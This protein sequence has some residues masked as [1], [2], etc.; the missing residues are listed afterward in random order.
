M[1]PWGLFG[2]TPRD[3]VGA[4]IE[5]CNRF[6][7]KSGPG[8]AVILVDIPTSPERVT[9][10]TAYTVMSEGLAVTGE[11]GFVTA[12]DPSTA[13]LPPHFRSFKNWFHLEPN[14][15]GSQTTFQT[16]TYLVVPP[17]YMVRCHVEFNG[18]SAVNRAEFSWSGWS[19]PRGDIGL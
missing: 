4:L 1:I 10:I 6:G 16:P 9:I 5:V 12:V 11:Y 17:G 2:L 7:E 8:L 15:I 19:I 3:R 14:T 13:A 18:V